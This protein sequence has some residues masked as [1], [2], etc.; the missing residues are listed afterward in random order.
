MKNVNANENE[1]SAPKKITVEDLK[2]I[3]GGTAHP[4]AISVIETKEDIKVV[5]N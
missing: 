5:I 1:T 4:L 3:I 2:K